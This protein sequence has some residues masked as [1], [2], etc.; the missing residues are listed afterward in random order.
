MSPPSRAL[1]TELTMWGGIAIGRWATWAWIAGVLVLSWRQVE[2][3]AVAIGAVVLALGVT[4]VQ[5]LTVWHRQQRPSVAL[6]GLEVMTGALLWLA[7]G[8]AFEGGHA[9]DGQQSIASD[10]PLIA[11]ISAAARF[12]PWPGAFLGLGLAVARYAGSTINGADTTREVTIS[13]AATAVFYATFAFVS[14]WLVRVLRRV[15]TEVVEVRAREEIARTLHD[16]VLQTLAIVERRTASSD[17]EL[18]GLARQSDRELRAWLFHG[19]RP[20]DAGDEDLGFED[21]IRAVVEH[22]ARRHGLPVT[23]NV[24]DDGTSLDPSVIH[25]V[26]G[27]L[28]EALTNAAKHA[29]ASSVIVFAENEEGAVF[30]SVRDDGRGFDPSVGDRGAGT[31]RFGARTVG[32]DRRPG[33]DRQHPWRRNGS[34]PLVEASGSAMSEPIRTV[35]ADDHPI[36]RAGLRS[37]LGPGFEVV[38]EADDADGAIDVITAHQP[39][40]VISDLHMPRGG[41]LAVVKACA[42]ICPIVIVTVSEAE[43][44]LL[45]AIAAGAGGY[46][47]KT[48]PTAE[49]RS[50]LDESRERGTGLLP[51]PRVAGTGGVPPHGEAGRFVTVVGPRARGAAARGPRA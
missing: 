2:R 41:G 43:R 30:A 36:A 16:G 17:P 10:W 5:S 25:A 6:V 7:D 1:P 19:V 48:T 40:L 21:R 8:W 24:L 18:S 27:A 37:E 29:D 50:A 46:L 31:A 49:L 34:T 22:A 9:V 33:R 13:L 32:R 39:Q 15:E 3:P 14:G 23:V 42:H 35:I 28:G 47:L 45:D 38:G 51:Y 44:D 12:G 20:E 26:A 11:A 4:A